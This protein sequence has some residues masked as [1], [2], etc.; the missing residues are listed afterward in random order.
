MKT[1]HLLAVLLTTVLAISTLYAPQ[2]LLPIFRQEFGVS[3]ASTALLITVA[4]L[5]LGLAPL[6]YGFFLESFSSKRMMAGALFLLAV[7][8]ACIGLCSTFE[9][10]LGLR[11][12]QGLIIPAM[13]TSIM[14]YLSAATPAHAMRRV[15]AVYIATTTVGGFCG[16]FFAGQL[17]AAFSWRA[18][19][20][21][22]AVSLFAAMFFITSLPPDARPA[23]E[24][25]KLS[26]IPEVLK[27]PGFFRVYAMAFCIFFVFAAT[28]NYLPYRLASITG[29]YSASR[30]GFMYLGYLMGISSS[31]FSMRTVKLLGGEVRALATGVIIMFLSVCLFAVPS[32]L[33]LFTSLFVLC[34]GMFLTHSVAPGAINSSS[35]DKKGVTNGLYISFYYSGGTLG[36]YLPG[37]AQEHFGWT[38]YLGTLFFVLVLALYFAATVKAGS[39]QAAAITHAPIDPKSPHP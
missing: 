10:V 15:M 1:S 18:P 36:S 7:T 5:P 6:A 3:E 23:F 16:R 9:A 30:T 39:F 21:A 14:T 27:K 4:M 28:L 11:F 12:A 33:A 37:L 29:E 35:G 20:F 19:F 31:L 32:Q 17:A 38:A 34:T 2:P 8:E 25:I 26:A 24:R 22:L 13:L